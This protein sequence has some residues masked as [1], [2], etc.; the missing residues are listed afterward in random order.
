MEGPTTESPKLSDGALPQSP[1]FELWIA[2]AVSTIPHAIGLFVGGYGQ[3]ITNAPL[4]V[5][6][7]IVDLAAVVIASL[8][9]REDS[10]ARRSSHWVVWA[11]IAVGTIWLVYAVFV[12][13]VIVLGQIFCVSKLCR[14]PL[15]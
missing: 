6:V 12:G 9:F 13:L 10:R 11:T 14:P 8:Q 4:A 2:F 3:I 5:I 15:Y 1:S 7:T